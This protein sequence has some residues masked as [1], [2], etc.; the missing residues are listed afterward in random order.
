MNRSAPELSAPPEIEQDEPADSPPERH[1]TAAQLAQRLLRL[2][3]PL[4]IE[5]LTLHGGEGELLWMSRGRWGPDDEGQVQQA[6][7]AFALEGSEPYIER[8]LEH[9]RR[10]L[11]FCA[12]T[13]LGERN[14]LAFAIAE[15]V[16]AE[17][18]TSSIRARVLASMQRYGMSM[19]PRLK[20]TPLTASAAAP[21]PPA[22]LAATPA[23]APAVRKRPART[24]AAPLRLRRYARLHAAGT[25]RR[26]EI[27]GAPIS[28]SAD[29]G[30]AHRLMPLLQRRG[31]QS[32]RTP[33]SFTLPLSPESVLTPDFML[34]F[35]PSIQQAALPE[36]ML[37][38]SIATAL[39]A[40]N[41][42]AIE[43]FIAQCAAHGCFVALDDFSLGGPGFALLRGSAVRC[44]K[45]DRALTENIMS[46]RFARAE[47]AA[48][49]KAARVLG[50]YCV[51]KDMKAGAMARWL[52]S[53][54]IDYALN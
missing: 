31:A 32:S 4:Q 2:L 22:T 6:G 17:V 11:F 44:L 39:A 5:R 46:E 41:A 3:A 13:P 51:A 49:I 29:L 38:F 16:S 15:A 20:P 47:V 24:P 52:G 42:A 30:R 10:A 26:Y 53:A 27:A 40:D 48:I 36:G 25:T 8:T 28:L 35:A 1:S 7:L 34:Q 50:L 37:G 14:G 19:V 54:G 12:R 33:A 43:A 23:S 21:P 45:L 18:D 9:G